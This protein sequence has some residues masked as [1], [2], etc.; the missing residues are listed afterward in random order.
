MERSLANIEAVRP[1]L[2]DA[3]VLAAAL[4]EESLLGALRRLTAGAPSLVSTY[5]LGNELVVAVKEYA[6]LSVNLD[7][8]RVKIWGDWK[9]RLASAVKD[10]A[11]SLARR[12]IATLIDKGENMSSCYRDELRALLHE[13]EKAEAEGLEPLLNRVKAILDSYGEERQ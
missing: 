5:V 3:R 10:E 6:L 7:E 13:L 9:A 2:E 1:T 12:I 4:R 11:S 8:G